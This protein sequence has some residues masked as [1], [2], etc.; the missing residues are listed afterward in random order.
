MFTDYYNELNKL[1]KDILLLF[2]NLNSTI[3]RIHDL[4]EYFL[5]KDLIETIRSKILKKIERI[6]NILIKLKLT[7]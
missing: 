4:N 3:N 6:Q 7:S 1:Y 5:Y 2:N